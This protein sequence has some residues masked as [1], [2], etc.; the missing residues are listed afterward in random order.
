MSHSQVI[1]LIEAAAAASGRSPHT[2]G[3]LASGSGDFYARLTRGHDL[4]TR[5]ADRVIRYL[6][7][8]WPSGAEWPPDIPRPESGDPTAAARSGA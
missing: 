2:V 1:A 6:S 8:R 7:E 3:R 5:R 4:T